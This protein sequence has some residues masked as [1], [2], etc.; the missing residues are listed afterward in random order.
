[1]KV[2][3]SHIIITGEKIDY[4]EIIILDVNECELGN[5]NCA[6]NKERCINLWGSFKC[7]C[8]QGFTGEDCEEGNCK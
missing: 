2:N 6:S 8:K 1:M 3:D 7:I 5:H 4:I